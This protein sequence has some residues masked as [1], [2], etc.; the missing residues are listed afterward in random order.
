M[1]AALPENDKRKTLQDVYSKAQKAKSGDA[2]EGERGFNL[3]GWRSKSSTPAPA[4]APTSPEKKSGG[5]WGLGKKGAGS[6]G[7]GGSGAGAGTP[8][9]AADPCAFAAGKLSDSDYQLFKKRTELFARGG[10]NARFV[11]SERFEILFVGVWAKGIEGGGRSLEFVGG[12]G[13]CEIYSIFFLGGGCS[14]GK[15]STQAYFYI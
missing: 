12:G 11:L 7:A 10:I 2:S 15:A 14:H 4:P 5:V 6:P 13:P 8:A 1:L 3:F 9:A